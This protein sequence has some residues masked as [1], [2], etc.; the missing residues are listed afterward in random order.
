MRQPEQFAPTDGTVCKLKRSINGLHQ[1]PRSWNDLLT[2]D[3]VLDYNLFNMQKAHF[4]VMN[5][6]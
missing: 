3:F 1:A 6:A 2:S 5:L 4:G